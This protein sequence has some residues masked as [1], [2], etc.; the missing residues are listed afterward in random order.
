MVHRR[1]GDAVIDSDREVKILYVEDD[2]ELG[3]IVRRA[4]EQHGYRVHIADGRGEFAQLIKAEHYDAVLVDH[5]LRDGSGLGIIQQYAQNETGPAFIMVTG[6]ANT[7]L[8]VAAM[9]GGAMDYVAK[10]ST[11]QFLDMLPVVIGNAV[12]RRAIRNRERSLQQEIVEVERRLG[13]ALRSSP[14]PTLLLDGGGEIHLV[15]TAWR[16]AIGLTNARGLTLESL[17]Y[18]TF[19]EPHE[20]LKGLEAAERNHSHTHTQSASVRSLSGSPRTWQLHFARLDEE[21]GDRARP[22]FYICHG[23]DISDSI[24]LEEQLRILSLED[25]LTGLPNRRSLTDRLPAEIARAQRDKSDITIAMIDIDSFKPFNDN[26]GHLAG[27]RCLER[28]ADAIRS[29]LKRPA[30]Y[31]ARFGGEEFA[32]VL[33]ATDKEGAA[34]VLESVRRHVANLNITHEYSE[35]EPYVTVSIG[36]ATASA[37]PRATGNQLLA[38]ADE[39]LFAAKDQGRNRVRMYARGARLTNKQK[40]DRTSA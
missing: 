16:N 23:L 21:D 36:Y 11:L 10:E 17:L 8:A 25:A 34:D 14:V 38:A 1:T 27:D 20:V 4:L 28:V 12:E 30:D 22:D 26:Y 29:A 13:N 19:E 5:H 18:A 33:P 37:L 3:D 9:R 15:N 35:A 31:V 32:V 2:Q 39:A 40:K 6:E 24:E 7:S